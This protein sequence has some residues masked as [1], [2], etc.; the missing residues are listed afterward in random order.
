[1]RRKFNDA[2][3]ALFVFISLTGLLLWLTGGLHIG[4]GGI[5][6]ASETAAAPTDAACEDCQ[7]A[8][9]AHGTEAARCE[10]GVPILEC[11]SCRFETGAVKVEPDVERAL[12]STSRVET[13]ERVA[14][15]RLTGK[16][17][18]DPTRTVQV[19]PVAPGR[20][21]ELAT[22][23]GRVVEKGD[24]LAV[25]DS[26]ALGEAK[27]AYLD[28]HTRH[29]IAL[30]ERDR[31]AG[32]N[33]AVEK[34]LG[35]LGDP[36]H[37]A[38]A[39]GAKPAGGEVPMELVGAWRSKLLGA[40]ARLRAARLAYER[41]RGLREKQVSSA[42]DYEKARQEAEA[43]EA[44][45]A[46]LIEEVHIAID[47]DM[48]RAEAALRNVEAALRAADQR[49]RIFGLGEE[50]IAALRGETDS[51]GF[52]RLEVRAPRAGTI[53]VQDVAQGALV[54][55]KD[56]LFTI[57]DLSELW[58]W[59]DLY[60]RDLGLL[61]QLIAKGE[62]AEAR[63]RVAAFGDET[64]RGDLDLVGST[65][66]EKTRTVKVRI[67]VKDDSGKLK[68]NMFASIEIRV[69]SGE[70]TA[71]VPRTAV[72]SD[73]GKSFVFQR[74]PEST[75]LRRDVIVGARQ[76]GLIEIAMGLAEGAEVVAG[77]AFMLKSDILR[78]KMGAG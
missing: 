18:L 43:A 74:G 36:C 59:G 71:W 45:Y 1:M 44:E 29:D 70:K 27:A 2:G 10:H 4:W 38:G 47:L 63:I 49:L 13:H 14:V 21:V 61:H 33:A 64:F 57:A 72:L 19:S 16:V 7:A 23:L 66:D 65:V 42:S 26:A 37:P 28:A 17:A 11:A 5:R 55:E 76:G 68:A 51:R 77:G 20:V 12:L 60:E 8:D 40:S 67:R 34:L 3:L 56:S 35:E 15:L 32:L 22:A 6:A 54:E 30:R 41:E 58:V 69:P 75:W 39:A 62:P 50:A 52:A 25:I 73:E 46:S 78:A 24:L 48:L 9:G 31:Q 53:I